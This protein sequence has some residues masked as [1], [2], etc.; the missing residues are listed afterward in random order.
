[1]SAVG[2]GCD[3]HGVGG[4]RV[5]IA[6]LPA[7]QL[8]PSPEGVLGMRSGRIQ[9]KRRLIAV[10]RRFGVII[11]VRKNAEIVGRG[12]RGISGGLLA[13]KP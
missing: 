7:Q 6:I 4:A 11:S 13:S 3:D 8:R 2:E 1:M 12:G 9:L 10:Q 5:G